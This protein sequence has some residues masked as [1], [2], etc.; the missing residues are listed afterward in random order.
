MF[1]QRTVKLTVGATKDSQIVLSA[2]NFDGLM[3]ITLITMKLHLGSG[4]NVEDYKIS[5]MFED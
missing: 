5:V 1:K 2:A 4:D 3:E